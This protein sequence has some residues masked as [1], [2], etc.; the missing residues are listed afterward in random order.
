MKTLFACLLCCMVLRTCLSAEN[1]P[2]QRPRITGIDHF[3]FYTTNPEAVQKLYKGTL[4][5][6][7]ADPVEPGGKWRF[8]VGKQWIGYAPA[9]DP[10]VNDR[11]DH[12]AFRTDDA[13]AMKKYLES[14]GI[15]GSE[16]QTRADK[17]RAFVVKD[18]DGYRVEFV[19]RAKNDAIP[20]V[21]QSAASQ[22]MIHA[23]ILVRDRA[24][25]DKFYRDTLGFRLY[26]YGGKSKVWHL[27]HPDWVSMQVPDGTDWFEYMLNVEEN[28]S[29][30]T[31]GVM[32]HIS[33]G[34]KDMD[35]A[36]GI[37]RSHGWTPHG[38][39]HQQMGLDGKKQ[40]NVFDADWS[41]VELMEFTNA[42]KPCC[43]DF[44]GK[45]PSEGE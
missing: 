24:A 28:P 42:E 14:K 9:P 39:E 43:S 13:V 41:R 10:K 30:K 20:A 21:P 33:L 32:N 40:L 23:G 22:R 2:V 27:E 8:I 15:K 6:S 17:S 18:P 45:H 3:S 34:V 19:E 44:Q 11:M 1:A 12:V 25:A 16:I 36:E 37:L 31:T 29:L 5:L 4:G 26:W 7:S 38:D 35:K